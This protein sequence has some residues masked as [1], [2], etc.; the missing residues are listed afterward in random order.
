MRCELKNGLDKS[1]LSNSSSENKLTLVC[2]WASSIVIT[3]VYTTKISVAIARCGGKH[4][5]QII[6]AE[7]IGSPSKGMAE[8]G[9]GGNSA[10][11]LQKKEAG[12]RRKRKRGGVFFMGW[13]ER[14]GRWRGWLP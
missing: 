10:I 2:C 1:K 6:P 3:I 12:G 8:G 11:P 4:Y 14:G 9:C 7:K 13:G 5:N